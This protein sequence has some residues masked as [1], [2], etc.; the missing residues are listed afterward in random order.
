VSSYFEREAEAACFDIEHAIRKAIN[1]ETNKAAW[2]CLQ[3]IGP[4]ITYGAPTEAY[5]ICFTWVLW[6]TEERY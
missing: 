5:P 3:T 1:F 4:R 2:R 6:P